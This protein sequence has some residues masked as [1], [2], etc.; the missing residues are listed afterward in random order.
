MRPGCNVSSRACVS[1]GTGTGKTHLALAITA[2]LVRNG[3][4][5]R[6][7]N[8]VDLVNRLQEQ[9][10][11]GKAGNIADFVTRWGGHYEHMIVLDA[12]SLMTGATMRPPTAS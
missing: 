12:D 6:Y 11:L 5:A 7:Y 10:R 8:T 3:A 9:A 2:N 1:G 4:R